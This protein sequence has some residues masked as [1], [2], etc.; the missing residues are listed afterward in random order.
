MTD[1]ILLRIF[2]ELVAVARTALRKV[3]KVRYPLLATAF[4]TELLP[5]GQTER[6]LDSRR[7]RETAS[8]GCAV[9]DE[10]GALLEAVID[11]AAR[12]VEVKA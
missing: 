11:I 6:I 9:E 10:G 7:A 1:R 2:L 3:Q 8:S 4:A 5:V 12:A